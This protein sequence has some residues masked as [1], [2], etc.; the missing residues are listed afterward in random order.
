MGLAANDRIIDSPPDGI[1]KGD[2]VR[3]VRLM[4]RRHAR[5][6]LTPAPEGARAMKPNSALAGE[7]CPQRNARRLVSYGARLPIPDVPTA[8]VYIRSRALDAG[9]AGGGLP[10]PSGRQEDADAETERAAAR[11]LN[12]QQPDMRGVAV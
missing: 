9:A 3:I 4:A 7:F 8:A 12:E 6:G 11:G 1:G 5:G 2:Q 10:R